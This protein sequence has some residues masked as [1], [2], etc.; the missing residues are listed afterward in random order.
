[1]H[2]G[3]PSQRPKDVND[4]AHALADRATNKVFIERTSL[5]LSVAKSCDA[6]SQLP[7]DLLALIKAT[8]AFL[9]AIVNSTAQMPYGVR[10]VA[11]EIFRALRARFPE[12]TE[13]NIVR[14]AGHVVYY[15]FLQPAIWSVR[16]RASLAPGADTGRLYSAPET[17]GIVEGVV[18]PIQRQNLGEVCKMLNQ[19]SVGRKFGGAEQKYLEPL[20]DFIAESTQ[21]FTQWIL[22]GTPPPHMS[23]RLGLTA[24]IAQSCT[25]KTP[26]RTSAPTSMSTLRHPASQS[27]TS[28]RTTS[29]PCTVSLPRRS[30]SSYALLA[31]PSRA[32]RLTPFSRRPPK[33]TT[34]CG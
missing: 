26:R 1:M 27:S 34:R 25:S 24:A 15:R 20:N 4:Y 28:L 11:R 30:T 16:R 31:L 2:T 17:Y 32:V 22:E 13:E 6:H 19:I 5:P 7:A 21:V 12:E 3:L 33:S 29:T 23:A 9:T 10:F 14:I 18:P 8:R